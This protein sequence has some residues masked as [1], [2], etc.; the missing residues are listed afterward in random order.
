MGDE[1][2]HPALNCPPAAPRGRR[3]PIFMGLYAICDSDR[4]RQLLRRWVRERRYL[5]GA[6]F[7]YSTGVLEIAP[8]RTLGPMGRVAARLISG[9][10]AGVTV[11]GSGRRPRQWISTQPGGQTHLSELGPSNVDVTFHSAPDADLGGGLLCS[12]DLVPSP[13]GAAGWDCDTLSDS[14]PGTP[15]NSLSEEGQG[16]PL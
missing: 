8:R 10:Y 3:E 4:D 5:R 6:I 7:P 13:A 14:R 1:N 15:F 16:P 2:V 11:D 12:E 9:R